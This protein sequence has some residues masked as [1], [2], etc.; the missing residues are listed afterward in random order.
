MEEWGKHLEL[1]DAMVA[2]WF[3][4]MLSFNIDEKSVDG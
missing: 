2:L 4:D 1:H 3:C